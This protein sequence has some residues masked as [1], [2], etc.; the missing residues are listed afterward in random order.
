MWTITS[1]NKLNLN[2]G[3]YHSSHI[4]QFYFDILNQMVMVSLQ[5]NK[6]NCG[7]NVYYKLN[8]KSISIKLIVRDH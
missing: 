8:Q 5:I 7:G 2:L 1:A 6:R 3:F 4:N